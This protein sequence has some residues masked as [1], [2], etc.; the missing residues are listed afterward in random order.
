M[1]ACLEEQRLQRLSSGQLALYRLI[2]QRKSAT[3]RELR[4]EWCYDGMTAAA[5]GMRLRALIRHGAVKRWPRVREHSGG[6]EYV[7]VAL[8]GFDN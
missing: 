3:S 1:Q 7:Y 2:V 8:P 6:T 4:L 5:M